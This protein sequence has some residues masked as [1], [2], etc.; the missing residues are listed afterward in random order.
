MTQKKQLHQAL[1]TIQDQQ[2]IIQ[3][4]KQ[5]RQ[6]MITVVKDICAGNQKIID[7]TNLTPSTFINH[8]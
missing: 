1:K 4:M 3:K 2:V 5:E 7:G 8:H 6:E